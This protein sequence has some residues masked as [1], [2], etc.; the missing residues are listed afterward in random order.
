[1]SDH[2]WIGRGVASGP[3]KNS[4]KTSSPQAVKNAKRKPLRMAGLISGS[5]TVSKTRSGGAPMLAAARSSD[6]SKRRNAVVTT[7]TTYGN[8][9]TVY[10]ATNAIGVPIRPAGAA[11]K[12]IATAGTIAGIISGER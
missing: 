12:N 8:P 1:M 2:I 10:T 4:A 3:V 6:L 11:A 9:S 5:V 7:T